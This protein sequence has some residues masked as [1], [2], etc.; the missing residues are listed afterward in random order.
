MLLGQTDPFFLSLFFFPCDLNFS[1]FISLL[2]M[3]FHNVVNES[4]GSNNS[5][6]VTLEEREKALVPVLDPT[7]SSSV[8]KHIREGLSLVCLSHMTVPGVNQGPCVSPLWPER[9]VKGE[10]KGHH[11]GKEAAAFTWCKV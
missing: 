3:V 5:R 11:N 10:S 2:H 9:Q 6:L 1:V 8:Y 4:S 7:L